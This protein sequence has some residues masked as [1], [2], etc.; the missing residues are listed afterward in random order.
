M[1][2]V[3]KQQQVQS[4]RTAGGDAHDAT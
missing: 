2:L 3:Y 4:S 1:Y